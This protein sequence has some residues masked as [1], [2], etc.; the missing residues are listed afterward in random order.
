MEDHGAIVVMKESGFSSRTISKYLH[1]SPTTV[2]N[3][4]KRGIRPRTHSR[5]LRKP[6]VQRISGTQ[7]KQSQVP[8]HSQT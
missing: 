4:L 5:I 7:G 8:S 6:W 3:E 1:C 2:S